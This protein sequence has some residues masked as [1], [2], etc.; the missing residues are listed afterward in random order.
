MT[1]SWCLTQLIM[2]VL[3]A[4]RW[5]GIA[6]SCLGGWPGAMSGLGQRRDRWPPVFSVRVLIASGGQ[7]DHHGALVVIETHAGE[8][9]LIH[10]PGAPAEAPASL[11][12][13]RRAP[14]EAPAD[15]AVCRAGEMTG[16]AATIAG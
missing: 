6:M 1:W 14:G 4:Y 16:L 5:P 3:P 9:V 7:L 2:R 10:P 13:N 12:S 15:G 8:I 11:P